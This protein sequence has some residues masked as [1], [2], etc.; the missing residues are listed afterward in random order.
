MYV[1]FTLIKL[2]N[3]ILLTRWQFDAGTER[4][5]RDWRTASIIIAVRDARL[6][7]KDAL[8][9][10]V[11]LP[12]RDVFKE[13]SQVADSFPL[14]GGIGFGRVLLSIIFRSVELQLPRELC[15][16]D[17]GTL[18]IQ[19]EAHASIR[20][21]ADLA[22]CHLICQTTT[23]KGKMEPRASGGWQQKHGRPIRLAV[24]K[25]YASCLLLQFKKKVI[26]LGH[27]RAFSTLWLK[28]IPDDEEVELA[29]SVRANDGNAMDRAQL[30]A[31]HTYGDEKGEV[32]LR[33]RFWPGMSG[34]HHFM[35]KHDTNAADVME[36]L[37]C[38]EESREIS[39][40]KLGGDHRSSGSSSSSSDTSDD[41]GEDDGSR[42]LL[43]TMKEY[44]KQERSL[45]RRHRGLMQWSGVRH[46]VWAKHEIRHET[47]H[48]K[49]KVA[50][51][52]KHKQRDPEM[53]HE[54]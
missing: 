18:E 38:A 52:S 7:E 26:G 9:G 42:G 8:L 33:L 3:M 47:E 43:D 21:S 54:I 12:L 31:S 37:D 22:T 45:H 34:Y 20:L 17:I 16:L 4:F 29:L 40:K 49:N 14:I 10:V 19:P 15:G 24:Q 46:L 6:H 2:W 32:K 41:D 35:A 25:R 50:G 51:F 44:K 27:I 5:V 13:R 39:D 30:N 48:V 36:A 23:G 1:A 53:E 11:V 28:D